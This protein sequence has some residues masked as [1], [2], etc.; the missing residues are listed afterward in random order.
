MVLKMIE[1]ASF[2][3]GSKTCSQV[4]TVS[5]RTMRRIVIIDCVDIMKK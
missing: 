5:R 2:K 1:W 3:S 4:S